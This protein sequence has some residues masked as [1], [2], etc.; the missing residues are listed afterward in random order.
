[1]GVEMSGKATRQL[2]RWQRVPGWIL[3]GLLV[4]ILCATPA[5]SVDWRKDKWFI[6]WDNTLTYGLSYRTGDQDPAII[7]LAN[8]G[9]AFSVNGDDGNLNY[10]KG[11]SSNLFQL[12]TELEVRYKGFGM[13]FR[14][15]GFYDYENE[16]NDRARTQLND[17]ALDRVGSRFELRDA[18]AWLQFRIGEKPA[19][20]RLGRQVVNW[21][22]STFIQGGINVINPVDVWAIRTPGR[23][24]RNALLPVGLLWGSFSLT[25]NL[26]LEAFY[27]YEWEQT[28][29]DPTGSY[30][31]TNDFAGP[32]GEYVMLGFGTPPDIPTPPFQDPT[33]P[34]RPVLGVPREADKLASDGGQYGLALRFLAP[35]LGDT[36]FGFY[37]LNYHSRLPTINGRTGTAEGLMDFGTIATNAPTVIGTTIA[38][39]PAAGLGAAA[40]AGLPT[41]ASQVIVGTTYQVQQGVLAAGGTAAQAAAAAGAAGGEIAS[42]YATD[43]YSQTARY[44]IAYPED[45]KLYGFSFNSQ[46]GTTG[47]AWQGELSYRQNVPLQA[48]D[49]ELLFAALQPINP[50]FA[51]NVPGF[52]DGASQLTTYT[53]VDYSDGCTLT[54]TPDFSQCEKVVPGT[55]EMD[56]SQFQTTFTKIWSR[57]LG[58]DQVLLLWEGAV[59]YIPDLPA[60]EDL[61]FESAG[62]YTSGNPYHEV[63]N[64]G[65]A[66][67]GKAAEG[68]ERFADQTSWG[69]RLV[70]RFQYNNA[71][72]AV[73]LSPRLAWGHDVSGNSPGPGGNFIEGRK[74]WTLGLN[75]DYQSFWAVDISYTDFFGASR[76]NLIN[77]RD[78]VAANFKIA[79]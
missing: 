9:T 71:I 75:F 73:T 40:T 19:E 58:A 12:T 65:A 17:A 11:I 30:F 7:G 34:T 46:I 70:T 4:W 76:Y 2:S 1:M 48:D 78:F 49:V 57:G 28:I 3:L 22:E 64:P 25:D 29:I 60:K 43:A 44:F 59:S 47:L 50:V 18:Y 41:G 33:N 27:E 67:V 21:G 54:P 20:M 6:S 69:Y 31:S 63:S 10:D 38:A 53:G 24:L 66:H 68:P 13:F 16:N 79:F 37:Y 23:E 15:W 26:T 36:E 62:T 32:G 52:E 35:N 56:T 39:G 14:G 55:I 77:D 72:G 51:G 45:I 61:R 74:A 42:I 5:Y 8:G